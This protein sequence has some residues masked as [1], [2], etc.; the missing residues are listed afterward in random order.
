MR[1]I[2]FVILGAAVL[3]GA[4]YYYYYYYRPGPRPPPPPTPSPRYP[5]G[6]TNHIALNGRQY[7][8]NQSINLKGTDRSIDVTVKPANQRGSLIMCTVDAADNPI[9]ALFFFNLRDNAQGPQILCYYTYEVNGSKIT[10]VTAVRA[11]VYNLHDG[12]F[13]AIGVLIHHKNSKFWYDGG[14]LLTWETVSAPPSTTKSVA[15]KIGGRTATMWTPQ[16]KDNSGDIY[17]YRGCLGDVRIDGQLYRFDPNDASTDARWPCPGN[18]PLPPTAP[19]RVILSA[20]P[21]AF[22]GRRWF[23]G[24]PDAGDYFNDPDFEIGFTIE[25]DPATDKPQ[26]DLNIIFGLNL[27]QQTKHA[28]TPYVGMY[29]RRLGAD[30]KTGVMPRSLFLVVMDTI[31]KVYIADA[32]TATKSAPLKIRLSRSNATTLQLTVNGK[33]EPPVVFDAYPTFPSS[34]QL[35][36][37]GRPFDQKFTVDVDFRFVQGGAPITISDFS[38]NSTASWTFNAYSAD[39]RG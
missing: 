27:P 29:T 34:A 9:E 19:G 20:K 24:L 15:L 21:Y 39:A 17:N 31:Y 10:P 38:L 37:G 4:F 28:A 22:D 5:P 18:V 1:S 35:I 8:I 13:H 16:N 25:Y 36:F 12:N 23:L 3:A 26:H 2:T 33:D 7:F 14:P 6:P 32:G 11:Q 30:P